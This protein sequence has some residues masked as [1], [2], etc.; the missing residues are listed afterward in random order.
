MANGPRRHLPSRQPGPA[1]R[2]G[3]RGEGRDRRSATQATTLLS[4][5][6]LS[7]LLSPLINWRCPLF[8]GVANGVR[9]PFQWVIVAVAWRDVRRLLAEELLAAMP[10]LAG[11]ERIEPAAIAAVH[12]W[13]DR[14]VVPLSHA[15]LVGRLGQWVFAECAEWRDSIARWLSARRTGL[16]RIG[17]TSGGTRYLPSCG[18]SGRK[19]PRP[20]CCTPVWSRN[21]PPCFRLGPAPTGSDRRSGRRSQISR[22][23]ATGPPPA[24][25]PRWRSAVR[26]GRQAVE[27]LGISDGQ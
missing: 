7:P 13:F 22:W 6:S 20:A 3:K 23:P 4:P 24:G 9:R 19:L 8:P 17:T 1:S 14:P 18:R 12:L 26:S 15:A 27:G 11:A 21:R 25:R 10:E 5:F 2:K 16:G